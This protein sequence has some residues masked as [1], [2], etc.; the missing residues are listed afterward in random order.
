MYRRS[1]E[2][3]CGEIRNLFLIFSKGFFKIEFLVYLILTRFIPTVYT[4]LY[5]V[6]FLILA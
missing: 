6:N 4:E 5:D 2:K 3:D 1:F